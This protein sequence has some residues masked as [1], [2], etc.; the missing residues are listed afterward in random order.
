[1]RKSLRNAS[2]PECTHRAHATSLDAMLKSSCVCMSE[3]NHWG[4]CHR[5]CLIAQ[6][7]F[8]TEHLPWPGGS[9]SWN[10]I[11]SLATS[12][13]FPGKSPCRVFLCAGGREIPVTQIWATHRSC[14]GQHVENRL[15]TMWA[16]AAGGSGVGGG[17]ASL[18]FV[19]PGDLWHEAF[20]FY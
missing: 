1:M 11:L 7:N 2:H 5:T 12:S 13:G 18:R 17:G 16:A 8:D 3:K 10:P 15:T 4:Q 14:R 6:G 19:S 9:N 20:D